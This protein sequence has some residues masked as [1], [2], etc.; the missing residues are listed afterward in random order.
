MS[1]S[2]LLILTFKEFC[3][4]STCRCFPF[5]LFLYLFAK[6]ADPYV[7]YTETVTPKTFFIMVR[8]GKLIWAARIQNV[9]IT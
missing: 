6:N 7:T 8:L 4:E 1:T 9:Y 3:A 5:K 2:Q